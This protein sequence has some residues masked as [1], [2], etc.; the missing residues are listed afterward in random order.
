MIHDQGFGF[1][2]VGFSALVQ[3]RHAQICA[4]HDLTPAQAQLLCML[5]DQPRGMS[6]LAGL[7]GLAKPGLSGLVDRTERRGLVRR[8]TPSHD[9][10]AVL[11]H[12]TPQGRE[13]VEALW[14]D[15]G[16][17][18]PDMFLGLPA[19][20]RADFERIVTAIV[21]HPGSCGPC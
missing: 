14:T 12:T 5:R 19:A 9:R 13:T 18:L 3:R 6:E 21:M 20:D 8:E 7:L 4:D 11:L 2:L 17:R 15:V 16:A 1:R 10:R